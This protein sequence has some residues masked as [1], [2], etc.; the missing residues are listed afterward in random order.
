MFN[1]R[2]PDITPAQVTALLG[3]IIAQAVAFGWLDSDQSQ[4]LV[5]AGATIVAAAWK[6]ADALLRGRR[7]Q[8]VGTVA[9]AG[10]NPVT[11]LGLKS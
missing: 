10:Q 2:M 11:A 5:S 6:V 4:I 1:G 8:A 7:A 9:A 3:W